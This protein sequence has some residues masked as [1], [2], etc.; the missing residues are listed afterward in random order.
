M[1]DDAVSAIA[2][3]ETARLVCPVRVE[4]LGDALLNLHTLPPLNSPRVQPKEFDDCFYALGKPGFETRLRNQLAT[5]CPLH[6]YPMVYR[7]TA[8]SSRIL[9]SNASRTR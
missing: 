7:T 1:G 6:R 9:S 8:G 4:L 3:R 5:R 2:N